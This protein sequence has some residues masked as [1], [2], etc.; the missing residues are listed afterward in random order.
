MPWKRNARNPIL[1]RESIPRI[2]P[3]LVDPTSVF[4]PGAVSVDGATMLLL[5][6][7]SRGR[8]TFLLKAESDDGIEF[9]LAECVTEIRGVEWLS[10]DDFETRNRQNAGPT[11]HTPEAQCL[12]PHRFRYAVLPFAGD[13]MRANVKGVGRRWRVR[14]LSVQGVADQSVPGAR[15]LLAKSATKTCI[16]AIK[17][18]ESRDTLVVRLYNLTAKSV[19]E[20]L[21]FGADVQSAFKI[22]LLEEREGEIPTDGPQRLPLRFGPH[23]ILTVEVELAPLQSRSGA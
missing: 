18:H 19:D 9:R 15:G 1:T 4:N 12:G 21:T 5:R 8:R 14:P 7:Q 16:S 2:A 17:K 11:L 23:E 3:E 6:V 13:H 20:T 22:N 10:R